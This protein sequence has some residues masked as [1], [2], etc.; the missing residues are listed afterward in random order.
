MIV[1]AIFGIGLGLTGCGNKRKS[2]PP[3]VCPGVGAIS[4]SAPVV[5]DTLKIERP[6]YVKQIKDCASG[7]IVT[8]R[9]TGRDPKNSFLLKAQH[10]AGGSN[11]GFLLSVFNR[12]TCQFGEYKGNTIKPEPQ[13]FVKA[14]TSPNTSR[15]QVLKNRENHI[16]YEIRECVEREPGNHLNCTKSVVAERGT[17]ILFIDYAE[18]EV[19][20]QG[21]EDQCPRLDQRPKPNQ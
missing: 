14:H 3:N 20:L 17:V 2:D 8:Q 10:L 5:R 19:V 16:D 21:I 13:F 12:T 1:M 11:K 9:T 18:P 4:A 6:I 7:R 15:M